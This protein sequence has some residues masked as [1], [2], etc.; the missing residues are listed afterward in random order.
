MMYK[1]LVK[2]VVQGV[3]FRPYIY[4][5]AV[6]H[7]LKGYVKNTGSGVEIVI[8]DEH[9]IDYLD[10]LP[11]LAKID[12]VSISKARGNYTDFTILKS[13]D[14]SGEV[15]ELPADTAICN[16]CLKELRDRNNKRYGYYFI[17]CT[18]CG[19]RFT[20]IKDYPYDR[21]ETSMCN[22][23][24]CS[25]C[26]RE[27]TDPADRRYHAQTIACPSCGP[28][29]KLISYHKDITAKTDIE[30]IKKA[31]DIILKKEI[32]AIKGIGGFHMASL[33]C[34]QAVKKVRE[35]LNRKHKPFA[36][37]VKDLD[38]AESIAQIGEK[39][40]EIL[41]SQQRPIVVLKKRRDSY[42]HVSELD[43]L[44]IMLPYTPLHYL[45]FDFIKEPLLMT[46]CNLPG[47]PVSTEEKIADHF[48]THERNII[49]RCDDS[50]I[51][52]IR[53][54][55]LFLRRSRGFT[56]SPVKLPI[57]AD[58][59]L[60]VGAELNNVICATKGN[61]CFL[62]QY[63]GETSKL[64]TLDFMKDTINTF[65]RLTRLKP[66][67]VVCDLHPQY[68]ST[69]VAEELAK[70]FSAKLV[71][72]QHHHAHVASVAAE[73]NLKDYVGIAADGLGYGEDTTIWGGEIFD[74]SQNKFKRIGHL[75]L[76]P[77]LG[78][79]S[80][81]IHPK[82]M[83]FSI[84]SKFLDANEI[85][86]LNLFSE[87]EINVYSSMLA[88]N[89]NIVM[90]SSAG[91]IFDAASALLNIC[92]KR[93]YEGRPAMLLE[94]SSSKPYRI[95]PVIKSKNRKKI[96]MTTPLFEY[97]INNLNT[98][99]RRLSATVQMY[100]AEGMHEIAAS[101]GKPIV[102][103]GGVAYNR[104]I[105]EF[106]ISKGVMLNKEVPCGDGGISYGQ[107]YIANL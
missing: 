31:A 20:I 104:I 99:Y 22:F 92:Q 93:T 1:I 67:I 85:G 79:D 16:D 101:S 36:L 46:S 30:T 83:L 25:E 53:D 77:Q 81:A 33:S 73:H 74:V 8:N 43:S 42:N 78:G 21:H 51:K 65:V 34:S 26:R 11:P 38:M 102:F 6:Q 88:Y 89:F 59:T 106:M 98:D 2:G 15:T 90:T 45:L 105:S 24:M 69:I 52:V 54:K 86:K 94:S 10:D 68:N 56:P 40:K 103:S 19:P 57:L 3:G 47:N 39:E 48:L 80:S 96:L 23:E 7:N 32:V 84:L 60:S 58:D 12:S 28:K 72:V 66:K 41:T 27:Y 62:S 70:T 44:G 87:E 100:I 37:M 71:R 63:I 14:P 29:L 95:D 97:L 107:A 55:P 49:N 17:T 76:Q 75:E 35:L 91:R 82:K 9:F 5:K 61:K 50:V 13:A 4:R 64:E 18:N